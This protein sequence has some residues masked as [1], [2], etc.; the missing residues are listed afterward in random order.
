[1]IKKA[2]IILLITN[3]SSFGTVAMERHIAGYSGGQ[4]AVVN[5]LSSVPLL[6]D[7]GFDLGHQIFYNDPNYIETAEGQTGIKNSIPR[8]YM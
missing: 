8:P 3:L 5:S 7:V 6:Y 2:A 4:A 1:M